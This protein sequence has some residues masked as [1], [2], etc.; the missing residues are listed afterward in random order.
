MTVIPQ[1]FVQKMNRTF[2]TKGDRMKVGVSPRE[3][4]S[5]WNSNAYEAGKDLVANPVGA[6][7]P[8]HFNDFNYAEM[9]LDGWFPLSQGFNFAAEKL[10]TNRGLNDELFFPPDTKIEVG[11]ELDSSNSIL[12]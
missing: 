8:V 7:K 9:S 1:A 11:L 10:K 5:T 12:D 6:I 2:A 3:W 4:I